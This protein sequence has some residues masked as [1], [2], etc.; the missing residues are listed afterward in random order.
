MGDINRRLAVGWA[1]FLS[2]FSASGSEFCL[3]HFSPTYDSARNRSRLV[4]IIVPVRRLTGFALLVSSR[5]NGIYCCGI[6]E[7]SLEALMKVFSPQPPRPS[8]SPR[9]SWED[10][11]SA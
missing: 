1:C 9:H 6:G 8:T 5:R 7:L 2:R 4:D 3:R 11:P 10:L